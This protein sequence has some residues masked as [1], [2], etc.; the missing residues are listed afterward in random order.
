ME[1]VLSLV[2]GGLAAAGAIATA[3][4]LWHAA[5]C[6][7]RRRQPEFELARVRTKHDMRTF[8]VG[9]RN[10]DDRSFLVACIDLVEPPGATF[11]VRRD[12]MTDV[13]VSTRRVEPRQRIKAKGSLGFD[14]PEI[15]LP[16]DPTIDVHRMKLH[17]FIESGSPY[18][19]RKPYAVRH[20]EP[21]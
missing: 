12:E 3:G 17:F 2:L 8:N 13:M 11:R 4:L 14:L 16:D 20:E 1:S 18:I 7:R 6:E 19:S 9:V 5:R 10:E 15:V 21:V